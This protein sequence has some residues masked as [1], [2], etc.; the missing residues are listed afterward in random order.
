VY[1]V[2]ILRHGMQTGAD[3]K[4]YSDWADVMIADRFNVVSY[5]RDQSFIVPP[6]LYLF[7]ILIVAS[8]KTAL[9]GWWMHGVVALNWVCFSAGTYATLTWVRR[10]TASAAALLL[11]AA[12]FLVAA[13]LLIFVPFVLSDLAFWGLSTT[14]VVIGLQFA[15]SRDSGT[16]RRFVIG[17]LLIVI[18]LFFR[19]VALPLALFW[20]VALI[21]HVQRDRV[22]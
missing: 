16:V 20:I 19:P 21:V 9:G 15:T 18:A 13:D 7:W 5:L 1:G 10:S 12:L 17:T 8:L 22:V 4:S 3:T 11:T 6:V 14:I 2:W